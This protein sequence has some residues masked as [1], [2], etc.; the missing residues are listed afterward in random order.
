MPS[1]TRRQPPARYSEAAPGQIVGK[2]GIAPGLLTYASMHR[3]DVDRGLTPP[4]EQLAHTRFNRF[5]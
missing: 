4:R 1:A 3:T 5:A 2:N